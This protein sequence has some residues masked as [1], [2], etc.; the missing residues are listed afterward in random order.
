MFVTTTFSKIESSWAPHYEV[1]HVSLMLSK[2]Y[3]LDRLWQKS[4]QV[5]IL[6]FDF[7]T[8]HDELMF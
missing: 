8:F 5:V 7:L 6:C 4:K 3:P 1:V 2:N